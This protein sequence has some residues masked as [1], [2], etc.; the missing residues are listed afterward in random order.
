[1]AAIATEDLPN[2]NFKDFVLRLEK[3][4]LTIKGNIKIIAKKDLKKIICETL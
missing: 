3:P 4:L 2:C 1:M